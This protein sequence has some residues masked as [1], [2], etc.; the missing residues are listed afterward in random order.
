M[1][2][3]VWKGEGICR[4]APTAVLGF[5]KSLVT[6][7]LPLAGQQTA[8]RDLAGVLRGYYWRPPY[9][10]ITTTRVRNVGWDMWF[11]FDGYRTTE[12]QPTNSLRRLL[13]GETRRL[14]NKY[15]RQPL[16]SVSAEVFAD[17]SSLGRK[18]RTFARALEFCAA[19]MH[20]ML[21]CS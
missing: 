5:A 12:G 1:C 11:V 10:Y 20:V 7:G 4:V 21:A 16:S 17:S 3:C 8:C 14:C 18:R 6:A 19:L 15:P 2:V 13:N 9:C